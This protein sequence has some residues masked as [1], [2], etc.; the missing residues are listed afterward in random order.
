MIVPNADIAGNGA[1]WV[2]LEATYGTPV[3]PTA[4]GVGVWVPIISEALQYTEDKYYSPQIRQSAIVSDVRQ[5]YYHVEGDIVMEVDPNFLPYFLYASR[6]TVVKGG[7]GPYTYAATP[8]NVGA[9]YP[10]GTSKG[11]SIYTLR[12][13]VGFLY[14]GCVVNNWEFTIENG[15]LRVTM[16]MLGLA[17]VDPATST[18]TTS[19]IDPVLYGADAHTIFVD[20]AGVSPAFASADSTFNGF[21]WRANYNGS[22]QNRIVPDRAATYVAYGE[23]EATYDTELDFVSKTEYDNMKNNTLRSIRLASLHGGADFASATDGVQITTYR[24]NYDVYQVGL[25]GM[26]D[27]L[28]ARVTGRQIGIA[29]GVPFKIECK[30]LANIS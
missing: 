5:S 10:G 19:W 26:G 4:A 8:T 15:V 18:P 23:T 13:A 7:A 20:A 16:G 27:L 6:H 11:L 14:S 17:E 22:A 25:S 9:T 12:N 24:S 30:S 28:M 3:D 1:I 29:G 2:G 21:T